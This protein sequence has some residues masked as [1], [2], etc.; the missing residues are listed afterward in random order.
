MTHDRH[1]LWLIDG[2][3]FI[4]RAFHALP[5]LTRPDGLPVQAVYGF[6][7]MILRLQKDISGAYAGVVFDA[8]RR[9]FRQDIDPLYKAHRPPVPEELVPQFALIREACGAYHLPW[10]EQEGFEADDLMAT[11]AHQ[12]HLQG[13]KVT[14]VTSDKDMMALVDDE[15]VT[16]YDPIKRRHVGSQEV[17]DKFGVPPHQV[18]DV[19]ALMGDASDN[20]PGVPSIG[21]K[22]AAALMRTY[23]SLEALYEQIHTVVPEGRR[24]KLIEHRE[25]AWRSRQ[26]VALRTDMPLPLTLEELKIRAPDGERWKSFLREQ[27]FT[28]LLKAAETPKPNAI[29]PTPIPILF[30]SDSCV[31]HDLE[32]ILN[33]ARNSGV[34]TL[35]LLPSPSPESWIL[36]LSTKGGLVHTLLFS[37]S[38]LTAC[39]APLCADP[40]VRIFTYDL[41]KIMHC[42]G[43]AIPTWTSCHDLMLLAY[44]VRGEEQPEGLKGL[45]TLIKTYGLLENTAEDSPAFYGPSLLRMAQHFLEKIK[46]QPLGSLYETI[47]SPLAQVLFRMEQQGV[48]LNRTTLQEISHTLAE[49]MAAL[50]QTLY[51]RVEHRF[52]LASPKQLGVVLFEHLQL[53]APAKTKTGQ[54]STDSDVLED[55]AN[56]GHTVARHVLEWRQWAKLKSTYADGLLPHISPQTHRVHT[57]YRMTATSTGRLSSF[58]PNLQNL[59]TSSEEGRSIRS[60]FQAQKPGHILVWLDYSQIELRLLAHIADVQGFKEIFQK[61]GDIHALTASTLFHVPSTQITPDLRRHAKVMNFGVIY[62]MSPYGVARQLGIPQAQASHYIDAYFKRYPQIPQ[63]MEEIK[64]YAHQHGYVETLLGRRCTLQGLQARHA[65]Q[66]RMAER[67]AINAPL[68]GSQADLIKKAMVEIDTWLRAEQRASRLILQVHDE[69]VFECPQEEAQDIAL[70]AKNIMMHVIDLSV[71]LVVNDHIN[72]VWI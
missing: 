10:M 46:D 53:P 6:C 22:T 62:G 19:L 65:P 33:Q 37:S 49:K 52:N 9:T 20:I 32:S 63:Y 47:E 11:Y 61:G 14:L 5:S 58:N 35:L 12:A 26:L 59:P 71:P 38:H 57:T 40:H 60:A 7:Q 30:A 16:L 70:H 55:L 44:L 51:Q 23:G 72:T 17:E 54:Y 3:G 13:W 45:Q 4:F 24:Q 50:E 25:Q 28:S 15:V 29:D 68:Q 66:R 64:A 48:Y 21:L 56:Q 27:G 39:L 34:L 43:E 69:L 36:E 67:Q 31:T 8:G 2:S 42:F 18:A 41:K 1:H